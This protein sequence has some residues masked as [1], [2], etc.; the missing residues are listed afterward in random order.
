MGAREAV[1]AAASRSGLKLLGWSG[2]LAFRD[3]SGLN[4]TVRFSI[5]T[6]SLNNLSWLKLCAASVADQQGVEVEHLVQDAC[7]TDGT[8]AWLRTQPQI[9]SVVEPDRGMYDGVNRGFRRA[10]GELLAYLNCDEQYLPGALAKVQHYFQRHPHI[11]VA[12]GDVVVVGKRG[13]FICERRVLTPH[14]IHTR[15]GGNLSFF[16]AGTFVR[17]TAL[18]EHSL[19]F[20]PNYRAVGDAAWALKVLESGARMGVLPELLSVFVETGRNLGSSAQG[21]AEFATFRQSAPFKVR[22]FAPFALLAHRMRRW[23]AKHY[24]PRTFEYSIF[25]QESPDARQTFQV[26]SSRFRWQRGTHQAG[27]Y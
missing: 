23:R 4:R 7:S 3:A 21:L 15:W 1:R 20:D 9:R 5:V 2:L 8:G 25:T 24:Q 18:T 14:W 16:T 11:D 6:P 17:R 13:E 10:S 12:F 19:Y 26:S 22:C 27:T